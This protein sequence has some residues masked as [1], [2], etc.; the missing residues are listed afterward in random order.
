[1]KAPLFPLELAFGGSL[2]SLRHG[3]S[4]SAWLYV[5]GGMGAV[6]PMANTTPN[7]SHLCHRGRLLGITAAGLA[8]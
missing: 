8:P 5:V 6:A 7:T 1:M 2:K 3:Q 4:A